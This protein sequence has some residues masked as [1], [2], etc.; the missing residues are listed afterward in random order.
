MTTP[1]RLKIGADPELFLRDKKTGLFVSAHNLMPGTKDSPHKVDL[2]A[3][4]VDGVAAEFNIDP[5]ESAQQFVTNITAVTGQLKKIVGEGFELVSEPTCTFAEDYFKS[6]PET[7]RELG[8]NPDY[9]AWTGQVNVKPDG[10]STTM[11]TGAG[12]IHLGWTEN[13]DP[14][15]DVHFEDCR[16]VAKQL[17]YYLGLYSLMWDDDTKRRTLYGKAGSFRAKPYGMEYRPLSNQW[18]ATSRLQSWVWNAAY[19]G[20]VDLVQNG[21]RLED[22]L[23]DI[24]QRFIDGN[25]N[26]WGSGSGNKSPDHMKLAQLPLMT[27]LEN[28]PIPPKPKPVESDAVKPKARHYYGTKRHSLGSDLGAALEKANQ[29]GHSSGD[30]K[31]SPS[32]GSYYVNVKIEV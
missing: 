30:V 23:G 9:N 2:G 19:R 5:T 28:P 1:L 31:Y 6:L 25:E 18:L 21:N 14:T 29:M 4:Q 13:A 15:D 8:C 27:G 24:A 26:W 11:R 32:T 22:K 7:V 12:H 20:F 10:D 3:I 16:I 17:D